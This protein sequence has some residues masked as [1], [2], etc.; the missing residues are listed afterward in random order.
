[1]TGYIGIS[2]RARKIRSIYLGVGNK[3]RKV[4]KGYIGVNGVARQFYSSGISKATLLTEGASLPAV[5]IR[6]AAAAVEDKYALF[7][8]GESG[9]ADYSSTVYGYDSDLVA[10]TAES[11]NQSVRNNGASSNANYAL[12]GGGLASASGAN[13]STFAY[14]DT[15]TRQGVTSLANSSDRQYPKG[16]ATEKYAFFFG[17]GVATVDVY[18]LQLVRSTATTITG[19]TSGNSTT[20]GNYAVFWQSGASVPNMQIYDVDTLEKIENSIQ[21]P[22]VTNASSACCNGKKGLFGGSLSTVYVVDENLVMTTQNIGT[23]AFEFAV[24]HPEGY[25]LAVSTANSKGNNTITGIDGNFNTEIFSVSM[26]A[27]DGIMSIRMGDYLF[28]A[29]GNSP[30]GASK[31]VTAFQLS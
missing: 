8:G 15:L 4:K 18:D 10:Y 30:N 25:A 29:G 11:F 14:D 13:V 17:G 2:N 26:A 16:C 21:I 7:G 12:F 5:K 19:A 3:A 28:F 9:S 23:G 1:M 31:K 27:S 6:G 20:V 24:G 22:R